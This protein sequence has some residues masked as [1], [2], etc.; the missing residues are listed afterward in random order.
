MYILYKITI[1]YEKV[2][3]SKNF[4]RNLEKYVSIRIFLSTCTVHT[5]FSCKSNIHISMIPFILFYF[6]LFYKYILLLNGLGS[7]FLCACQLGTF[8]LQ[9]FEYMHSSTR[10]VILGWFVGEPK[11]QSGWEVRE[12]FTSMI[13]KLFL[14]TKNGI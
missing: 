10:W 5:Q 4:L 13:D 12:K 9:Q 3:K 6:I 1:I 8:P 7:L 14:S 11:E 2:V